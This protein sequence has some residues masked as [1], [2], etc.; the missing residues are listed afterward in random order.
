[1][2]HMMDDGVTPRGAPVKLIQS[3][4][5]DGWNTEAPSLVKVEGTFYLFFSTQPWQTTKYTVSVATASKIEGPYTRH[6]KPV[7]F[8]GGEGSAPGDNPV[9]PG[10]ADVMFAPQN[11]KALDDGWS[12]LNIVFHA[13]KSKQETKK[14]YLWNGLLK[15]KGTQVEVV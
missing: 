15:A 13:A 5:A 10:G 4:K 1:M 2:Q 3:T 8:T 9:A 11:I 12:Q 6:Q 7:L 14:R